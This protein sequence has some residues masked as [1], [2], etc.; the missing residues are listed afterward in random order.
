M[1]DPWDDVKG[2]SSKHHHCLQVQSFSENQQR[3]R[4]T[5]AQRSNTDFVCSTKVTA[6]AL[7]AK[8]V[9]SAA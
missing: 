7:A 2:I 5:A 4:T 8:R 3:Q 9:I 1:F 6:V